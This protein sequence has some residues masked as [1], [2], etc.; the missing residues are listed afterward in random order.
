M[1]NV[2]N[3]K[4]VKG[5]VPIEESFERQGYK[6]MDHET[7]F[8]VKRIFADKNNELFFTQ[9]SGLKNWVES[10]VDKYDPPVSK[11][12]VPQ[13]ALINVNQKKIMII[14]YFSQTTS[15]SLDSKLVTCDFK[16]KQYVK[17]F[18]QLDYSIEYILVINEWFTGES[19]KDCIDYI[20]ASGCKIYFTELKIEEVL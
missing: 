14:E 12:L 4:K 15:G 2:E 18:S 6:M 13:N 1:E 20:V 7:L 19:Y 3:I 17:Q 11:S 10:R 5:N 9:K 8:G 16:R